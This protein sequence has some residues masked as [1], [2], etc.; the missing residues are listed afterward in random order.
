[1]LDLIESSF[2]PVS[3]CLGRAEIIF[4]RKKM[5]SWLCAFYINSVFCDLLSLSLFILLYFMLQWWIEF[6]YFGYNN[7][8]LCELTD[9]AIN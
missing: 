9:A 6:Q 8:V 5:S 2:I 3:C 4:E 1:M 7:Y